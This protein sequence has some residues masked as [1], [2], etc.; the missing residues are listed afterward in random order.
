[1]TNMWQIIIPQQMVVSIIIVTSKNASQPY[2]AAKMLLFRWYKVDSRSD[3]HCYSHPI[4]Y[5]LVLNATL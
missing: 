2:E 4:W 3:T 5:I 1:M